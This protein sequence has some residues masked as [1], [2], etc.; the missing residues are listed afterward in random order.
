MPILHSNMETDLRAANALDDALHITLTDAASIR[1]TGAIDFL[2]TVNGRGSDTSVV[3]FASLD[4]ADAFSDT[5]AEDTDEAETGLTDTSVTIAVVRSAL[6]RNM[7]DLAVGTGFADDITPARLAADMSMSYE[8]Y[9]N[10]LVATAIATASANVGAAGVDMSVNDWYDAV[11]VL[12][13]ADVPGPYWAILAPRQLADWQN[14]LRAEGGAVKL[15][16]ATQEM[17]QIMGQGFVGTFSGI[18][19]IKSSDVTTA[20][21][22]REG[23]MFGQGAIGYKTMMPDPRSFHGAG[24]VVA[25]AV[26]EVGLVVEINRK[27]SEALTQIAGNAFTGV[28]VLEQAR[29]VGIV[30]DA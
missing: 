18:G 26:P 12:E 13:I 30:T 1:N 3:R 29:L 6:V 28:S 20:A 4:G 16:P 8:S 7:G 5:A 22:N 11:F 27:A 19:I 23:A 10:G 14:S 24:T 2:G 21:G 17:L 9:F 25:S 15:M